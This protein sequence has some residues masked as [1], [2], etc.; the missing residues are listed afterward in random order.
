MVTFITFCLPLSRHKLTEKHKRNI[1]LSK[2]SAM[3]TDFISFGQSS[4][5]SSQI[6]AA[7]L[8]L[9][10]FIAEHN[11]PIALLDHLPGLSPRFENGQRYQGT[12]IFFLFQCDW[13][14]CLN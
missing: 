1:K 3:V 7:K 5:H 14:V 11:L 6:A 4:K 2:T 8:K 12:C 10:A 13:P 9:C